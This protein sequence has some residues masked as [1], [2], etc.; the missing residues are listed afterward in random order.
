MMEGVPQT[1]VFLLC[2]LAFIAGLI[3]LA[4]CILIF[5]ALDQIVGSAIGGD[6]FVTANAD[7]LSH[8]GWL[9]VS[10]YGVQFVMGAAMG[11]LLP[12]QLKDNIQFGAFEISPIGILAMLLVFVLAQI[13]RHGSEMRAELEG[14][15]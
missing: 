1:Y 6:P 3:L 13:F 8:I 4:L 5:R 12:D 14:T 15:V 10:V 7:R 11:I 2:S 9:L